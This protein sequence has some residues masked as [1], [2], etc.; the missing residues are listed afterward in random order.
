M[1]PSKEQTAV[2]WSRP[3]DNGLTASSLT[4]KLRYIEAFSAL[5]A[6][7]LGRQTGLAREAGYRQGREETFALPAVR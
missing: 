5:E 7:A 6:A 2:V 3:P 4:W 1:N